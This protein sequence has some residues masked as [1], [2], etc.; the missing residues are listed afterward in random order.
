MPNAR[1]DR[2]FWLLVVTALLVLATGLGLRDPWPSDEP[3]F[4]LVARQMVDS[5]DWLLPRRGTELY[6]DKPPMLMWLQ[7]ASYQLLGNWRIAFL[8]PSLLAALVTLACVYDLGRRLWNRQ[9]GLYAAWALLFTVQFTFQAK[10]AQIDPLVVCFIT[11]ANYGLLRHL[12]RGPDWR[13]WWLGWLAAGLGLITKGVGVLALAMLLPAVW[14]AWQGWRGVTLGWRRWQFWLGPA[15]FVVPAALWLGPLL[16]H[17]WQGQVPGYRGY[18]Y[19]LLLRQTFGRYVRSWDHHHAP[20]YYLATMA[21]LWLPTVL[22]LPW[23][24]PAWW[25]RLRRR[26]VRYL[27]P[28]AWWLLLL[29]FFSIPSGKRDVY[30]M[31]ALPMLCLALGPLLPGLLRRRDCQWLLWSFAAL[32][33]AG[34]LA[35]GAA[36]LAGHPGLEQRLLGG[37]G[38]DPGGARA[39]A[40]T[41]AVIGAFGLGILLL[42]GRTR[43]VASSLALLGALWLGY[44]LV[45]YRVLNDAGSARGLMRSVGERL[46]P[47]DE[48]GLVAWKEQVLLMADRP[49]VTFGFNVRWDV[50]LRAAVA[51]QRARPARRWLLVQDV[52][53]LD[54][55]DRAGAELAGVANR[56]RWWLVPATALHGHCVATPGQRQRMY[57]EQGEIFSLPP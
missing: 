22:A 52:A 19:D 1:V 6:S 4:A 23:A 37:R 36:A 11:V 25:R 8:L 51:W 56:R 54:C 46:A 18:L 48:L 44:A 34:L 35:A 16:L 13:G 57:R 47:G 55:I 14:A 10:K 49:A 26:D 27:L 2:Q 30:L 21:T 20:A 3:R 24:L 29:V 32:L 45:G 33:A 50:Q 9:A 40:A 38:L 15:L 5:G 7:A 31:P 12:L 42:G 28:L 17:A 53:V 41:L 39:I 43:A